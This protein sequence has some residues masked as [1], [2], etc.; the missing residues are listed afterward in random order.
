MKSELKLE[1]ASF[2]GPF[3]LLLHLIKELKVNINDIPM[4]EVTSQYLIYLQNMKELQLDIASEYLV[5]AAS[6][7]EIK[8][9]M[10][11]PIEPIE[12]IEGDYQ[13]D[14]REVLVQQ[15]LIYQQFQEVSESLEKLE[16]G[17]SKKY[18]RPMSNLAHFSQV[19][20]LK[21]DELSLNDLIQ[22]FELTLRK[23]LDRQPLK[24]EI[25]NE[26][27]SVSDKIT[28]IES[29]LI[30]TSQPLTFNDFIRN[31][32][33]NEIITTFMA[34]LELVRKQKILFIQKQAFATIKIIKNESQVFE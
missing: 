22:A 14:P 3:D 13:E 20:P 33:R 17:R 15:L 6:L 29:M 9:K 11:L 5:M 7:I 10:L 4:R 31:G 26:S 18:F 19:I 32:S 30:A 27:I 8:S 12:S 24:R 23:E 28:E 16:A 21:E 34:L 1:L 2:Q 25:D